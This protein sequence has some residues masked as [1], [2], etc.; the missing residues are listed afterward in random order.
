MAR[1][2]LYII[3]G[4][5]ALFVILIG[6]GVFALLPILTSAHSNQTSATPVV[7]PTTT[8]KQGNGMGKILKQYAPDIKTQ[9]A[10]GLHMNSNQFTT[11]LQSGKTLTAVATAQGISTTQLQTVVTNALETGLK[12]AVNDGTLTQRQIDRLAKRYA[13]NPNTLDKLLGDKAYKPTP[14]ITPTA[15]Q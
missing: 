3:V 2:I 1:R 14:T 11:Q 5:I 4:A 15:T 10:Q 7:S 8:A 9:I 12:P 13:K 6:V